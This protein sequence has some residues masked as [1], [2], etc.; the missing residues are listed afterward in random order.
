[1][2]YTKRAV[3]AVACALV[4]A[5][6]GAAH[7]GSGPAPAPSQRGERQS[8]APSAAGNPAS[9]RAQAGG[10]CADAYQI[11][12]T[13]YVYRSGERIA[14]VKQ[15][16]SPSCQ[17]NYGYLWVWDSFRQTAG[18]YDVSVAVYSYSRDEVLGQESWT[19]STVREFWSAGT[20]TVAECT[21]AVG[22][23]RKAGDPLPDQAASSK[24]C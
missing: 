8:T 9:A 20:D 10:V 22:A 7:A 1:M 13:G 6:A 21:A 24:R 3:T 15:F 2:R 23:V 18:D 11:G 4:L 19:N 17:E 16:Y 12:T 5:S 14:S